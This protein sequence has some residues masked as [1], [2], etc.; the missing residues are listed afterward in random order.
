MWVRLQVLEETGIAVHDA[1]FATA[2]NSVFPDGKHYVTIFV[3]ATAQE[4][5]AA[6]ASLASY[7]KQLGSW[8]PVWSNSK[9]LS[10]TRQFA[11]AETHKQQVSCLISTDSSKSSA[12]EAQPVACLIASCVPAVQETQPPALTQ[13]LTVLCCCTGCRSAAY[14][15]RQVRWLVLGR[16]ESVGAETISAPVPALTAAGRSWVPAMIVQ[17]PKK[18]LQCMDRA[19]DLSEVE[20]RKLNQDQV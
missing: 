2:E 4:V 16:V 10:Q 13:V 20:P 7:A 18:L 8:V 1:A 11:V 14:G 17:L 15:A 6:A 3:L 5:R 12:A 19:L 9:H